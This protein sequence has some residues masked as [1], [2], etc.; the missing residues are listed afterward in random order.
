M[1]PFSR[2]SEQAARNRFSRVEMG[3]CRLLL[4]SH[5]AVHPSKGL[6][7]SRESTFAAIIGGTMLLSKDMTE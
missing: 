5:G 2:N 6:Q 4:L 1:L 7:K 3:I